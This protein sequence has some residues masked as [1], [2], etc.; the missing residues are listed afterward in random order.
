MTNARLLE[1]KIEHKKRIRFDPKRS[2]TLAN[3]S[4]IFPHR[5][6]KKNVSIGLGALSEI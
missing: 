4:T 1:S 3:R 5:A 2:A 6:A